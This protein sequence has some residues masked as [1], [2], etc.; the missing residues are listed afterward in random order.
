MSHT[1]SLFTSI[2]LWAIYEI[3]L[4]PTT[5]CLLSILHELRAKCS[6]SKYNELVKCLLFV[7]WGILS[8][9][10]VK[11]LIVCNTNASRS[12]RPLVTSTIGVF[13]VK[14]PHCTPFSLTFDPRAPPPMWGAWRHLTLREAKCQ[15]SP[16]DDSNTHH[17]LTA[18]YFR[19][20][21]PHTIKSPQTVMP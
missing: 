18:S 17:L 21:T 10:L 2:P 14:T 8:K 13:I 11:M 4:P 15:V 9:M 16:S 20:A 6:E 19:L 3:F 7:L 1:T 5:S 12:V